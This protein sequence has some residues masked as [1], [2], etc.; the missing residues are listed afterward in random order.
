[1]SSY[2]KPCLNQVINRYHYNLRN[3]FWMTKSHSEILFLVGKAIS[4]SNTSTK[5]IFLQVTFK[6]IK[7][8]KPG[9]FD[10]KGRTISPS[11][12]N[13]L[14][15]LLKSFTYSARVL[16]KCSIT[17]NGVFIV[18]PYL[19]IRSIVFGYVWTVTL[20]QHCDFLLNVLYLIFSF[21]QIN[22]FYGNHFLSPIVNAF[23]HLAKR[24]LSN[25]L[26]FCK[27]L[28]WICFQVLQ[29]RKKR[30]TSITHNPGTAFSL[31]L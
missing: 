30:A 21:F 4:T 12:E 15:Y 11:F 28:F 19:Q 24:A 27:K 22:D 3:V 1:M 23:E 8:S 31:Y 20:T 17:E 13:L 25:F 14:C 6:M 5:N 18:K 10:Y 2:H 9:S 7:L 16:V 26:Q 29:E